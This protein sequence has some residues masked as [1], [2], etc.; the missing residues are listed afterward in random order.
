MLS[1]GGYS[2]ADPAQ[3]RLEEHL[4]ML[5]FEALWST[6]LVRSNTDRRTESLLIPV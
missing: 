2:A 3:S 5:G 1:D 6:K 4:L